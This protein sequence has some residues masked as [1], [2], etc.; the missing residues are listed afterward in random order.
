MADKSSKEIY[1]V[2]TFYAQFGF[3]PPGKYN[4]K[5]CLGSACHVG[6]GENFM[7]VMKYEAFGIIGPFS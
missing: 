5:V 6:G 3:R 4:I 2:A 1:R 7:E